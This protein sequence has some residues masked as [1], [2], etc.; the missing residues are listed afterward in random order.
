LN[1]ST[2]FGAVIEYRIDISSTKNGFAV[3]LVDGREVKEAIIHAWNGFL[4]EEGGNEVPL[5][6]EPAL[7]R[8]FEHGFGCITKID[9]RDSFATA[10]NVG[11]IEPNG[12]NVV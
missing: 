3:L 5:A 10:I 12:F 1:N 6:V 11:I 7:G 4:G 2:Y 9:R 8:I